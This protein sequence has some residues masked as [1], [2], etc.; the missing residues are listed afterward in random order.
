MGTQMSLIMLLTVKGKIARFAGQGCLG[1]HGGVLFTDAATKIIKEQ[2]H[3][4]LEKRCV[5]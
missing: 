1:S 3:T 2:Q 4:A 5:G